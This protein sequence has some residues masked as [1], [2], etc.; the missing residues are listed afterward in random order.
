MNRELKRYIYIIGTVCIVF[1]AIAIVFKVLPWLLVG[2]G[3]AYIVLKIVRF[4]KGKSEE[5]DITNSNTSK[6]DYN[7]TS[8]EYTNGDVI[9]VE[10]ED[11]DNKKD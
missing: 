5:K 9:D 3:I 7:I 1:F 6:D 11:V 2:G 4:I 10:Y 8:D